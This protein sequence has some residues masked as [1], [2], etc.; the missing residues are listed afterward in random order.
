MET[1]STP[2]GGQPK[3]ITVTSKIRWLSVAQNSS[4]NHTLLFNT[5]SV[6]ANLFIDAK[7]PGKSTLRRPLTIPRPETLPKRE[8]D[9]TPPRISDIITKVKQDILINASITWQTNETAKGAVTFGTNGL[10]QTIENANS[11]VTNHE[12]ILP[13]LKSNTTYHGT[14]SCQDVFGNRAT[15]QPFTL[16]TAQISQFTGQAPGNNSSDNESITITCN[17]FKISEEN[18]LLELHAN[19]PVSIA[20]GTADEKPAEPRVVAGELNQTDEIRTEHAPLAQ[21]KFTT[22]TS[23][24]GCHEGYNQKKSHP[25]NILPGNKTS[26]PRDYPTLPD[27]RISC[28]TCHT[29]HAANREYR[30]IKSSRK[31][32]CLGCHPDKL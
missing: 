14:I 8:N 21:K 2:I 18:V 16:S 6:G 31:E 24:A 7:T 17:F 30:L 22:L 10:S 3:K 4:Q 5:K 25:V 12:I 19:Q 26:I 1:E 32:L 15:S 13:G 20:A 23:C 27:G 9:H 29:N 11:L 28:M